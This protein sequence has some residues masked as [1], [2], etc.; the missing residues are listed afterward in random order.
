MIAGLLSVERYWRLKQLDRWSCKPLC[1]FS[2]LFFIGG[3]LVFST[4]ILSG[5]F[6][7]FF[8]YA[9]GW[10]L[11]IIAPLIA[12]DIRRQHGEAERSLYVSRDVV[13][14]GSVLMFLGGFL[15]VV[16]LGYTY[17]E[18]Y[19][20][21]DYYYFELGLLVLMAATVIL[22]LFAGKLRKEMKVF[23]GKHFYTNKYDYRTEWLR[24]TQHLTQGREQIH[25]SS[26]ASIMAPFQAKLGALYLI[27]GNRLVLKASVGQALESN[28]PLEVMQALITQKWI[29]DFEH[30]SDQELKRFN[31]T[32]EDVEALQPFTLFVPFRC[33][34]TRGVFILSNLQSGFELDYEDRDFLNVLASHIAVNL[35]LEHTHTRLI[36]SQQFESFHRTSAFVLHDLKNVSAQLNMITQNAGAHS[37]N[38]EFIADTF[39]TV[40][41]ASQRLDKT[42]KQLTQKQPSS[43]VCS[44]SFSIVSQI[45]EAINQCHTERSELEFLMSPGEDGYLQADKEAFA[46]VIS[47]IVTNALQ[48]KREEDYQHRV[49]VEFINGETAYSIKIS[50]N[51]VGMEESFIAEKLFKPFY[52]TKGNSGMGIG[53]FEAKSFVESLSGTITVDSQLGEG[54]KFVITLPK[55][56]QGH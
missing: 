46:N 52:T 39:D 42:V 36:E 13:F 50:D 38:P 23:I 34:E 49:E 43:E 25:S 44:E 6:Y 41:S 35:H 37:D 53:A 26:L 4:A 19:I 11:A 7:S 55:K 28:P 17:L 51:G 8:V 54:S 24:F 33:N 47:H 30:L 40:K 14:N 18:K 12:L 48:A 29:L 21:T 20:G 56:E 10:L 27:D 9:L 3:G 5:T 15:L 16:S 22:F 1:L 2:V 32:L 45:E 31:V